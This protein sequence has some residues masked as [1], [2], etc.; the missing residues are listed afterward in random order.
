VTDVVA[1]LVQRGADPGIKG[2]GGYWK[3]EKTALELAVKGGVIEML[4]K[5]R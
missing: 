3:G 4:L 5:H 1:L 2:K